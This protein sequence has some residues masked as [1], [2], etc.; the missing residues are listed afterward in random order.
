MI[1][2]NYI[3]KNIDDFE[4][5]LAEQRISFQEE[6][7]VQIFTANLTEEDAVLLAQEIYSR[8]PAAKIIG[9]SASGVINNGEQYDKDTLIIVEKFEKSEVV[10]GSFS[11]NVL[12]RNL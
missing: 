1:T 10:T 11:W 5:K 3:F 12:R 8:M 9:A 4:E 2:L 7:L 6:C